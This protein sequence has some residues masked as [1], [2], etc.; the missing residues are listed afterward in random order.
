MTSTQSSTYW[1]YYN[2]ILKYFNTIDIPVTVN[3]IIA[4]DTEMTVVATTVEQLANK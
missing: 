2:I 1:N 3:L 4:N